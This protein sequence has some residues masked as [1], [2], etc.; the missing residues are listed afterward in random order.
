MKFI[1]ACK[2]EY[3]QLKELEACQ[4][5]H[6]GWPWVTVSAGPAWPGGR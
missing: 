4:I 6:H 3:R 1:C 5:T 2:R